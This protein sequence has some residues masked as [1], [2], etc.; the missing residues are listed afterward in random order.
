[1]IGGLELT[2]VSRYGP[3]DLNPA[4]DPVLAEVIRSQRAFYEKT[5]YDA[6]WI[7]YLVKS[8]SQTIGA[9]SFKGKPAEGRVEIAYFIFPKFEGLGYGTRVCGMLTELAL[10]NDP[11]LSVAARTLRERNASVRILEKNG[12]RNVGTVADPEDGEVWEWRHK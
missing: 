7:G 3:V 8:G 6:P 2:P 11:S 4:N 10:R 9:C 12:F 5:G 1:M